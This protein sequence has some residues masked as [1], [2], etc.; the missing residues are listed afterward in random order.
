MS[1]PVLAPE[2]STSCPNCRADVS[3]YVFN[4]LFS[5]V[6]PGLAAETVLA[7]TESSCFYHPEKKAAAICEACGRFMCA[8]CDIDFAGRHLCPNCLEAGEKKEK[9]DTLKREEIRHDSIALAIAVLPIL[10][11]F[12]TIVTAPFAIYYVFKHWR[13]PQTVPYSRWQYYVALGAACLQ[14]VGWI[15]VAFTTLA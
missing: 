3:V 6:K 5:P 15:G 4:A 7:D 1:I 9:I 14:I 12:P 13:E 10:M 8:L 11:I 2:Q